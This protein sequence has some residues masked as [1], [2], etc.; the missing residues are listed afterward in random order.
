MEKCLSILSTMQFVEIDHHPTAYI[1]G[2]VQKTLR[3]V[4]TKQ[5][6]FVYS[7]IYLT[8]FPREKFSGTAK[9]HKV[10]NNSTVEQ[11]SFRQ[12]ISS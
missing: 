10:P 3:K 9:L 8:E 1:E 6:L 4:K 12:I 2:K 5:P 7:K 11:L